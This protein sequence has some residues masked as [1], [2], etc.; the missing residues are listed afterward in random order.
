MSGIY[1][2]IPFCKQKCTYCDFAS[3]P[4]EIGKT[5]SYFACL[6]REIEARGKQYKDR[7]FDTVYFGG[8]TPSVVDAKFICG[9]IRQIRKCFSLT[10]KPEITINVNETADVVAK[11]R[12]HRSDKVTALDALVALNA[13]NNVFSAQFADDANTFILADVNSDF[14]IT[15]DDALAI[16]RL[17]HGQ[18]VVFEQLK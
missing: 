8:G 12:L 2:H 4:K 9:A 1:I 5:E 18:T 10:E 15:S 11:G 14:E 16:N 13:A 7:V 17:S 3:F 6:Y